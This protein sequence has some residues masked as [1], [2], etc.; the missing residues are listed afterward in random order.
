VRVF[1]SVTLCVLA[2]CGRAG[3]DSADPEHQ[4]LLPTATL[5]GVSPDQCVVE[6]ALVFP[7]EAV[8]DYGAPAAVGVRCGVLWCVE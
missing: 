4:N 6:L 3:M 7:T 1:V 2:A 8:S 5:V